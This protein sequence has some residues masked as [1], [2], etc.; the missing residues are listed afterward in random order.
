MANKSK[1]GVKFGEPLSFYNRAEVGWP[2]AWVLPEQDDDEADLYDKVA[3]LSDDV[4]L[5]QAVHV[6]DNCMRA[7]GTF[8][9]VFGGMISA[10]ARFVVG[11]GRCADLEKA[12]LAVAKAWLGMAKQAALLGLGEDQPQ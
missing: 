6:W 11:S 5:R 1:G 7:P 8:E 12:S 3:H 10:H 4:L 2:A 9:A